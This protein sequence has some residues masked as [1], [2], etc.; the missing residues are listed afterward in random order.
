MANNILGIIGRGIVGKATDYAFYNK[1][2]IL[3][4]AINENTISD[5][6]GC[7]IIFICVPTPKGNDEYFKDYMKELHDK[8]YSG[9]VCIR[10]TI[11]PTYINKYT[12][13]RGIT[14]NVCHVPEFLT[15][16]FWELD[17]KNVTQLVFGGDDG[18]LIKF[19][20][21]IKGSLWE[22]A[23]I[24]QT[25]PEIASL[26]KLVTN[27][28]FAT[29]VTWMNQ[30]EALTNRMGI[31]WDEFIN[32]LKMDTRIGDE[33]LQV[34]GHDGEYGYGGKC[35]PK[36]VQAMIDLFDWYELDTLLTDVKELNEI[37]RLQ[38]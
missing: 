37:F 11:N 25:T 10:S 32:V 12:D 3:D 8:E 38:E 21:A 17:A 28:F 6:L 35:F 20:K 31:N 18:T 15:E 26:M 2:I 30:L 19:K 7:D 14:L 33:H 24:K 1:A 5:L 23:K 22:D 9:V 4:P 13:T 16:R 27:S 29:K 34:P 36:D